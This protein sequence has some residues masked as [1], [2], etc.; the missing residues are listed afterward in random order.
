M[1]KLLVEEVTLENGKQEY[2]VI[3][4]TENNE[5]EVLKVFK[6]KMNAVKFGFK[7]EEKN[8]CLKWI[9]VWTTKE[10]EEELSKLEIKEEIILSEEKVKVG[11]EI[12]LSSEGSFNGTV[13]KVKVVSEK[14]KC[15]IVVI[16]GLN[17]TIPFDK[18]L[19][20]KK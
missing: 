19:L 7:L 16:K 2:E 12:Q 15:Y 4:L 10:L 8:E 11:D 1:K 9:G 13:A 17:Y 6:K 3:T 18:A 5:R 14:L 20:I